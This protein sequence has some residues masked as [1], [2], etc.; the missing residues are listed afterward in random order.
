MALGA[1]LANAEPVIPD[2]QAFQ[3][4]LHERL[5]AHGSY[6][7]IPLINGGDLGRKFAHNLL[8][9]LWAKAEYREH[10]A[11]WLA[12]QSEAEKDKLVGLWYAHYHKAF[13]DAFD[14]LN[15]D[16]V[17]KLWRLNDRNAVYA[18]KRADCDSQSGAA[19]GD[20]LLTARNDFLR[21]N[22]ES[23]SINLASAIAG[24]F[25]RQDH[26]RSGDRPVAE[27]MSALTVRTLRAV[28]A[29]LPGKDGEQLL[30][31]YAYR[32]DAPSLSEAAMCQRGWIVAHAV[33]D[34][35]LDGNDVSAA[36]MRRTMT[37]TAYLTA[38]RVLYKGKA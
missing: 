10:L 36:I 14:L 3:S 4:N 27:M 37:A 18:L 11:R 13:V 5:D 38:F 33:E 32:P 34:S 1:N 9:E 15:D 17:K 19:M 21:A 12:G 16:T 30:N 35:N 2:A 6:I 29:G 31:A 24:E 20:L 7:I 28:A 8:N 25:S 23:V 26:P 22:S